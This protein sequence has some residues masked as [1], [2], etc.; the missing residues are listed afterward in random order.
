MPME[1][2]V[3]LSTHGG[4]T[5][6]EVLKVSIAADDLGFNTLWVG[7]RF[8]SPIMLDEENTESAYQKML[9]ALKI[10]LKLWTAENKV[11]YKGKYYGG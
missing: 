8:L 6:K 9:E 3:H 7:D 2:G 10:I 4:Y 5:Y 1:F 11:T